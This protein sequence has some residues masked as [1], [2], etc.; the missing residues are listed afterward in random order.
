[1]NTVLLNMFSPVLVNNIKVLPIH[2]AV[3]V[4]APTKIHD[5]AIQLHGVTSNKSVILLWWGFE[6]WRDLVSVEVKWSRLQH[7]QKEKTW[8]LYCI[9][10]ESWRN[11]DVNF[12]RV[13]HEV[14]STS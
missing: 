2:A 10:V 7:W 6:K 3:K 12:G 13:K 11:A 14:M 5:T 8:V 1:M 9:R 4:K